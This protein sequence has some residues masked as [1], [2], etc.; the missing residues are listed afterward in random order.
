MPG[1]LFQGFSFVVFLLLYPNRLCWQKSCQCS[2]EETQ[3]SH[4]GLHFV[5]V[6]LS[7]FLNLKL[8][9]QTSSLPSFNKAVDKRALVCVAS[10]M[11]YQS[12]NI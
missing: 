12:C 1:V 5:I 6:S 2:C 4:R 10:A 9:M 11:R 3:L 8:Q 7:L